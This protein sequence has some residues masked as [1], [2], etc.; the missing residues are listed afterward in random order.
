MGAKSI[1]KRMLG[2]LSIAAAT[3]VPQIRPL[4]KPLGL[5]CSQGLFGNRT[6]SIHIRGHRPL[7]LTSV[8]ESYLAFQLFWRGFD[9]YEPITRTLLQE[10]VRPGDTFLDLGA[11]LGFYSLTTG[12][13]HSNAR[14]VAFEPNPKNFR[15]LQ[16]N[17]AANGLNTL[18]CEPLAISDQDAKA[19]LYL[20]ESDMSASL[21]KDF[22]IEDTKQIDG[23]E[24][25]TVSLDSYLR[26][27][28]IAG[29][30]VIKVDI[31]GHEPAFFRGAM[32]TI[33]TRKPDIVIE[34]LYDQEAAL[35]ARLKSLG[36]RF[37]PITNESLLEAET[38]RLFK[39]FPFLFL[40]YLLSA[41]PKEELAALFDRVR[42]RTDHLNLLNTSKHFP[43]EE[44]PALWRTDTQRDGMALDRHSCPSA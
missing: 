37:Y 3:G 38:P 24:V 29:P 34:V 33:T 2:R 25:R 11:H 42:S 23:I 19:P 9:Y 18:V 35:T 31:E 8:D 15:V 4:L 44:W 36:Y 14:I 13:F 41:R 12:I 22:Q 43:A 1:M 21:M 30:V 39:R 17:A 6:V 27:H 5:R 16:K 20:T 26:A 40:N 28:E 32:E 7:R 10:L